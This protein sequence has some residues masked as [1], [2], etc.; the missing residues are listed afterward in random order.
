[1]KNDPDVTASTM[2]FNSLLAELNPACH[3]LS[4]SSLLPEPLE[5]A[6]KQCQPCHMDQDKS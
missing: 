5:Y 1:M 2:F 6:C 3:T 4:E